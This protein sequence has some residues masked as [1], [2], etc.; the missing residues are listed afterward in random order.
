MQTLKK[1]SQD[2]EEVFEDDD[3]DYDD[4]RRLEI[5]VWP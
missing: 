2:I 3:Y 1:V 5:R 4:K